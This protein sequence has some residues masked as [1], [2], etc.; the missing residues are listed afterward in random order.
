[1]R[2]AAVALIVLVA[3]GLALVRY[4]NAVRALNNRAAH[5]AQL[6]ATDRELELAD[7]LGISTAFV[8]AAKRLVPP[9]STYDVVTGPNAHA[10]SSLTLTGL[11]AYIQ[12]LLMPGLVIQGGGDWLLCYGCD[13]GKAGPVTIAWREGG[14]VI[15]RRDG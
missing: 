12:N 4:P 5:N 11:G 10:R 15:A 7:T 13:L 2:A 6:S 14:L 9:G 3:L 8:L 1:V